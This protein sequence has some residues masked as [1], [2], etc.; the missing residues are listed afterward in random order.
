M[1]QTLLS[2]LILSLLAVLIIGI[3][4]IH[5]IVRDVIWNLE[6][7]QEADGR[8]LMTNY[9]ALL[10]SDDEYG[11]FFTYYEALK[12]ERAAESEL[13][14]DETS[15]DASS[16][17]AD[18]SLS[19]TSSISDDSSASENS[20]VSG[21]SSVS[22]DSSGSTT[23]SDDFSDS[24][25]SAEFGISSESEVP[26]GSDTATTTD[27]SDSSNSSDS[28]DN[29][30]TDPE[31]TAYTER[32]S[33]I[34][35]TLTE[36]ASGSGTTIA[37]V[38][39][40]GRIILASNSGIAQL[41][42]TALDFEQFGSSYYM[43]TNLM[44]GTETEVL[45]VMY[46]VNQNYRTVAYIMTC[47]STET[48]TLECQEIMNMIYA[49]Y[50]VIYAVVVLFLILLFSR[51]LPPVR[52]LTRASRELARGN[53]SCEELKK[54]PRYLKEYQE[55][56]DSMRI[57]A[58]RF[59]DM[60]EYQ[61]KFISN[62]SHDFRS[63][64]TSIRGYAGA[65]LD[66]T[67]P[68]ENQ[69]RYLNIILSETDRLTKMANGLIALNS[70]D[71]TGMKLMCSDFDLRKVIKTTLASFEH[72]C[73]SK[74]IVIDF[75]CYAAEVLVHADLEKIRQV[76]YNL[77]DNAIKF[78][79][80]NG[81]IYLDVSEKG[82]KVFVSVKD[83]GIGI[84]KQAIA[85]IWDRFYKADNSRGRDRTGSGLGLAIVKEIVQA[86]KEQIDV[87]STEGVG[88]EFIFTM[89][90]AKQKLPVVSR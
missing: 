67:I 82:E 51:I 11:E 70:W 15:S 50:A 59:T 9:L 14:D 65:M 85:K 63:P 64:L 75:T 40:D 39:A 83:H 53:F 25:S 19:E 20:A 52:L 72:A 81:T 43:V 13:K 18:E 47:E 78:S 10:Y 5:F 7:T 77:M 42:L 49:T 2:R 12:A 22:D 44:V 46:P 35:S 61:R 86:H 31:L 55:L 90:K 60:E 1:R 87:V 69:A 84:P 56:A 62:V 76:I 30:D 3:F 34:Q 32:F 45:A 57:M 27:A 33:E 23:D 68:P 89:T 88:T 48:I 73:L 58:D 8:Y 54:H 66:G 17:D 21:G 24:E 71:G 79:P 4:A 29:D 41:F 28:S 16:T 26:S 6:V 38:D 36:Y 74:H 37:L 80:Q